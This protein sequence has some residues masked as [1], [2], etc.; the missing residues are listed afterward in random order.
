MPTLTVITLS[1][2]QVNKNYSRI[3][4]LIYA[5]CFLSERIDFSKIKKLVDVKRFKDGLTSG[6][7]WEDNKG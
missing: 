4:V 1:G 5:Q 6:D 7:G 2:I 3:I